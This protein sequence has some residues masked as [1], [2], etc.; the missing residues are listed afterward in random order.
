MIELLLR[1]AGDETA[2]LELLRAMTGHVRAVGASARG[3]DRRLVAQAEAI[4]RADPARA[5]RFN[6]AGAATLSAGGRTWHAGTFEVVSIN[7]LRARVRAA[8]AN[9][10][11]SATLTPAATPGARVRLFVLDGASPASDIGSLQASANSDTVFQVASQF[12][13]LESP[14]PYVARVEDYFNDPTQGPRASISAF[15]GTLLRHYAAPGPDGQRFV[16]A[17]DGD[18][19]NLLAEVCDPGVARVHC[20]YL[21]AANIADPVAF[22]APS[23]S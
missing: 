15:P 16:Q 1:E 19:L 5:F 4:V 13:C 22:A 6:A 8:K 7:V 18:Q 20:G 12:N 17:T 2:D 10:S 3:G 11:A 23:Q 9:A 14:G 21:L